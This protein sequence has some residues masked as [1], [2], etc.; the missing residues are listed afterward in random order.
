MASRRK[1]AVE[2]DTEDTLKKK[3]KKEDLDKELIWEWEDDGNRWTT[4]SDDLCKEI[5]ENFKEGKLKAP[6]VN[7]GTKFE[8]IFSRM[9]QR[10]KLSCWERQIRLKPNSETNFVNWQWQ[11][12]KG[13]W[14]LY[15]QPVQRLIYAATVYGLKQ[16]EFATKGNTYV[17]NFKRMEQA[18]KSSKARRKIRQVVE[19]DD[20]KESGHEEEKSSARGTQ[21]QSKTSI[22]TS[23][24]NGTIK[25]ENSIP[26]K[27]SEERIQ[28]KTLVKKGKAPVDVE[29]PVKN[30]FHV[31]SE[32]GNIWDA[33]LNQTNLRNNNNK[34]Y[35][36]QLL[37]HDKSKQFAVW[38]RW[39]RVGVV[40]QKNL[41]RCGSNLL[42][43]KNVFTKKFS[44]KT[45]NEW[46]DKDCFEKVQGKYDLLKMDYE[47]SLQNDDDQVD[48]ESIEKLERPDS[49]LDKRV[50]ALVQLICNVEEMEQA[51]LE[52][53]YDAK[54]APLGKLTK[55]QI[56]AGYAALKKIESFIRQKKIGDGIVKACDEFYT[57]IPHVFGM[58][59]PPLIRTKEE[60]QNKLQLLE[61]LGDIEIALKVIKENKDMM[62]NPID[63]HYNALECGIEPMDHDDDVFKVI[64]K[65]L[66][67]TH[68]KTHNTY[69]MEVQEIFKV[70]KDEEIENFNDCGN[71]ML[72]WH[73]SRL[74]N[75]VGIL[76]QGLRIAPP[77]APVTG[78]MFG[79]GIYFADMSSK[80]ANYC[81]PSR[82]RP[83]GLLLLSE[84][85]LGK[86]RDLLAADYE[87]D[88]LPEG[89]NS[90]K[91]LGK[92][93]P[94]PN[95]QHMLPD[96][97][98]VPL[99]T[100]KDTGVVNPN[101]YT[102]NYNE[103]IVYNKNQVKA[104]YLV[105]IKFN[106]T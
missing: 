71:R 29:C 1:R 85:A 8:A 37:E 63:R 106:F 62:L 18:N 82:S 28:S 52:M 38:F 77:E 19:K 41:V 40:G 24:A 2:D 99:G 53:K 80:S 30:T 93:A 46:E 27:S 23:V 51:V 98:I 44:D 17:L 72:L 32:G 16:V 4:Y 69:K 64:E 81:Y 91:G 35:L 103:F 26:Q 96:G 94:D 102:L 86:P 7:N 39:G 33:M 65:Y 15:D 12:E 36:L 101:G 20:G 21:K 95:E 49:K 67:K 9:V 3:I 34:F 11:D 48:G 70:E 79:K 13:K 55:E 58:Q 10:N 43:A 59:R 75:Y 92:T 31:F 104:K 54:K 89:I 47:A 100:P 42:E 83:V 56:N 73:G 66:Q 5:S 78:Y 88:Q 84:V 60:V 87:A 61:A 45:K 74:T 6:F 97:T 90:V 105:Q 14:C 22:K 57:R 50:Q 76:K 68:A 25:K